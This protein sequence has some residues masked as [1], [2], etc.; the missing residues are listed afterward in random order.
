[1]HARSRLQPGQ[2][3]SW[4]TNSAACRSAVVCSNPARI[5][6]A[7]S[8]GEAKGSGSQHATLPM[9]HLLDHFRLALVGL[10]RDRDLNLPAAFTSSPISPWWRGKKQVVAGGSLCAVRRLIKGAQ[11]PENARLTQKSLAK[12]GIPSLGSLRFFLASKARTQRHPPQ[13]VREIC[14]LISGTQAAVSSGYEPCLRGPTRI[15][16]VHSPRRSATP[17][18]RGMSR[19]HRS[20]ATGSGFEVQE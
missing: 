17:L 2:R 7:W 8:Q 11:D 19:T 3:R 13:V 10:N 16:R 9:S 14:Q 5:E 12:A 20:G 6:R 15:H 1:M 4:A 18:G